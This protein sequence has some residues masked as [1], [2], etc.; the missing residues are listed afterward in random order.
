MFF[1]RF[2]YACLYSAIDARVFLE[3]LVIFCSLAQFLVQ[4]FA[5]ES[6][7]LRRCLW[8]NNKSQFRFSYGVCE[9]LL[10]GF[11]KS[12]VFIG[13]LKITYSPAGV[14]SCL[15]LALR[16]APFCTSNSSTSSCIN[17]KSFEYA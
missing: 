6:P 10:A 7:D 9:Y 13:I 16:S 8:W 14:S 3:L 12:V 11:I 4:R 1:L 2:A 15:F 5:H 17:D